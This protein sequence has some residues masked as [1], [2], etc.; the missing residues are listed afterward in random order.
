[1]RLIILIIL[2]SI[3]SATLAFSLFNSEKK[4]IT[5]YSSMSC[6]EL[7]RLASAVE[8][9]TRRWRSPLFNRETDHLA[10]AIGTV[11]EP[12]YYYYGYS[13]TRGYFREYRIGSNLVELDHI[14]SQL[15]AQRCFERH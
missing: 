8:P 10:A 13:V 4:G 14:R 2:V 6:D 11:L 12:G 7:Y 1:M 3:S 5:D 15:A 9:G